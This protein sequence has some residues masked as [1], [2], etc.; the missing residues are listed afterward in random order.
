[1]FRLLGVRV[2]ESQKGT[3]NVSWHGNVHC[4]V[5]VV[6]LEGETAVSGGIPIFSDLV[7]ALEGRQKMEGIIPVG[8]PNIKVINN[9]G[10]PNVAGVMLPESRDKGAGVVAMWEQ[11]LLELVI[12]NFASLWQSIHT[13]A[14]FDIDMAMV[15]KCMEDVVVHDVW[16]DNGNWNAHV[17]I[18]GGGHWGTQVEIFEVTHHALGIGG[19]HNAVEEQF[20]GDNV[21]HFSAH[22]TQVFD[23][24]ATN[25]PA[26]M[27]RYRFFGAMGTNNVEV[28]GTP[29]RGRLVMGMKNMIDT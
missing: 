5:V 16:W 9:Q 12:G 14:N 2:M 26:D 20:S 8:L 21:G 3:F 11:K 25:S 15:D 13:L 23:A 22:I 19:R 28:G 4:V 10:E 6:P 17:G 27:M 18:V 7:M 1:M 24:I 29:T